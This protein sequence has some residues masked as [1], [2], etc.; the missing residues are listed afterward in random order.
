[1]G[2]NGFLVFA[3]YMAFFMSRSRREALVEVIDHWYLLVPCLFA[4]G[5]FCLVYLQERYIAPFVVAV[6]L[7]LLANHRLPDFPLC[8]K[9]VKG[10]SLIAI[11]L[12]FEMTSVISYE[13]IADL[14]H[15]E[16]TFRKLPWEVAED[17][18]RAGVSPGD[19]IAS[20]TYAMSY[21]AQWA[22]LDRLKIVAEVFYSTE[23]PE[24]N[25]WRVSPLT[26]ETILQGF[27]NVGARCVISDEPPIGPMRDIW[28]PIGRTGY[29]ACFLKKA[30]ANR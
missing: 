2:L 4:L 16:G 26:Q 1:L 24:N 27:A 19:R 20:V 30:G 8:A 7:I 6:P 11:L 28:K 22:R 13:A 17:F 10:I 23:T 29:Y 5:M 3:V 25:F 15:H 12:L 18:R 9:L 21:I 14:P